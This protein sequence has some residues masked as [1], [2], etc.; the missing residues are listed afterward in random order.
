MPKSRTIQVSMTLPQSR[1]AEP[2]SQYRNFRRRASRKSRDDRA[3]RG[4]RAPLMIVELQHRAVEMQMGVLV[5][6][7]SFAPL[8]DTKTEV[9]YGFTV[10]IDMVLAQGTLVV[11]QKGR[12]YVEELVDV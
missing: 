6:R 9:E 3:D 12:A 10:R 4:E 5:V 11:L 2:E 8:I 1:H 7:D